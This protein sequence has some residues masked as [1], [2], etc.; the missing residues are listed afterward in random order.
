MPPTYADL[1][2]PRNYAAL[3]GGPEAGDAPPPPPSQ[4]RAQEP[5]PTPPDRDPP[6]PSAPAQALAVPQPEEVPAW[7]VRK[8][9]D[10][11]DLAVRKAEYTE[12]LKESD[13]EK[14]QA[15]DTALVARMEAQPGYD[16][17]EIQN[18][19][20]DVEAR[21]HRPDADMIAA[22]A[23]ADR[24]LTTRERHAGMTKAEQTQERADEHAARNAQQKDSK[25]AESDRL[26][27][28]GYDNLYTPD[29]NGPHRHRG[30]RGR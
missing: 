19:Q 17:R 12:A 21:G 18:F 2:K 6:T 1:R 22:Y 26:A 5:G 15:M 29:H 20:R 9:I 10:E 24:T 3:K 8:E 13:F 27:G 11:R 25:E 23:N 16:K 28:K 7:K 14:K 30:G 4:E